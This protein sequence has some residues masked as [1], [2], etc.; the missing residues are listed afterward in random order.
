MILSPAVKILEENA[1]EFC[2]STKRSP[3][4]EYKP[5]VLKKEHK[6]SLHLHGGIINLNKIKVRAPKS[7]SKDQ[8]HSAVKSIN[9]KPREKTKSTKKTVG[10]T[11]R[12]SELTPHKRRF[13]SPDVAQ[14]EHSYY[15]SHN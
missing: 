10:K 2:N 15:F 1:Y 11:S 14:I 7:Q 12:Q 4:P 9:S 5:C 6:Y 3:Q 13:L 8:R